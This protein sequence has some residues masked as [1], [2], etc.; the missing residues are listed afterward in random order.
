MEVTTHARLVILS[1]RVPTY[2]LKQV[3]Q[4]TAL[5]VPGARH[6]RNDLDV[7]RPG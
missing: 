5:N 1:G 3:A 7:T 6:L 2:Y 4:G